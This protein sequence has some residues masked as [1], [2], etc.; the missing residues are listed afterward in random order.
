[1]SKDILSQA[2]IAALLKNLEEEGDSPGLTEDEAEVMREVGEVITQWLCQALSTPSEPSVEVKFAGSPVVSLPI[3]L[4]GEGRQVIVYGRAS[5]L[6]SSKI[7]LTI[8]GNGAAVL[9]GGLLEVGDPVINTQGLKLLTEAC[10]QGLDNAS[11]ALGRAVGVGLDLRVHEARESS[12]LSAPWGFFDDDSVALLRITSTITI[13]GL[14]SNL[15]LWMPEDTATA[16]IAALLQAG[17]V[18]DEA[19]TQDDSDSGA[20]DE[21]EAQD[22]NAAQDETEAQP[23]SRDAAGINSKGL[24]DQRDDAKTAQNRGTESRGGVTVQ[25]AEFQDLPKDQGTEQD[26]RNIDIILDIPVTVSVEL[27]GT[28]RLIRDVLLLGSGSIV[29][30]DK[31]AGEPLDI[32]V[33]GKLVAKG[34]VVVINENYGIR[35]TDIISPAERINNLGRDH[36]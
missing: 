24:V 31:P 10:N 35:I 2:E 7:A 25:R 27:G 14:E 33:N 1:M 21:A 26:K 17:E 13:N 6:V 16:I 34:E 8:D 23:S 30:L 5:G 3:R 32:L 28:S 9:V 22:D 36:L 29:E 15:D 4:E 19:V 12:E 11:E 20:Q 18:Q